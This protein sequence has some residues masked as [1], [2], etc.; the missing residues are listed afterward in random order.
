VDYVIILDPHCLA[1][2]EDCSD[3]YGCEYDYFEVNLLT[4]NSE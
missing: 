1:Q 4:E 2:E 3:V